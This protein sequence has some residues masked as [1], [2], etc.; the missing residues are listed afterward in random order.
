MDNLAGFKNKKAI[1]Q[2][3]LKKLKISA[4]KKII[5]TNDFMGEF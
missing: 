4:T 2:N 5:G 1:N 3:T